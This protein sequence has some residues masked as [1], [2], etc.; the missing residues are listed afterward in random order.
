MFR[1]EVNGKTIIAQDSEEL[2]QAV[3]AVKA[4]KAHVAPDI[5]DPKDGNKIVS[6]NNPHIGETVYETEEPAKDED[7]N[8]ETIPT[9]N[10]RG[11]TE[12]ADTAGTTQKAQKKGLLGR[13]K[14]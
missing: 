2:Q 4:E 8:R 12:A 13:R 11:G 3:D 10:A 1:E 5:N 7:V 14:S 6:P 9:T